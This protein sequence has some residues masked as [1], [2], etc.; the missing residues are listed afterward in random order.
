[1]WKERVSRFRTAEGFTERII[2]RIDPDPDKRE[3]V[4]NIL[5]EQHQMLTKKFEQT[6]IEM[7]AQVDSVS[8]CLSP[9]CL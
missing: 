5:L 3:A 7:E 8:V 6:R 9:H 2:D 1:M 4:E